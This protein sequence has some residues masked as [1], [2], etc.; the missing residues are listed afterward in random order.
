MAYEVTQ[1]DL[2]VLRQGE[3]EI[4]LK[5][6]LLNSNFKVLDSLEGNIVNDSFSQD[7][8]SI[9]RRSYSCDLK[10][11]NSTF[12]IGK[13][14]K[15]W[16]DKRIRVFYG[17]NS[18]R[19]N[20][21]IWYQLGIFC[22][23]NMKYSSTGTDKTLSLTCGDLMALYD[24]TLN[25]QLHG[26]GSSP[27]APDYAVKNL[28]IPAGEDIRLSII[29]TL[30]E[31]GITKYI[32]ED[33]GKPIPYDLTFATGTTY[34]DV[35]TKIRDLYDSWEFY[36]DADGTFIWRQTP[37]GLNEPVVLDNVI[38]QTLVKDEDA[39]SKFTDIYNVTE[40]WG[41]V[42]EL[43]KSDRYADTS[44]YS[45]NTYNIN[46]DI[47]TS[48]QDVDNLTQISFKVL[49]DNLVA[50]KF[51]IN[52]L[53]PI[54]IY[55]GDG[56]PLSEGTLKA[57]NIYVFRYRRLTPEQNALFLLGQFQCYGRYVEESQD[58]PFSVPN[59]GYEIVNS[60]DYD[61]LSDDA[62]CY[63]QAEYLT[64]KS[65]AM[66]DTISL[67]ML[68]VPWLEVNTKIE[69]TPRYNNTKNQY[70]IKNLSWSTGEGVM[71]ATLYKFMESF[72]YVYNRNKSK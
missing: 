17:L 68:V 71:N 42:L 38:M 5:V 54:P 72:S 53:S 3:Q 6:E 55:D 63:N 64:Y 11:L 62:A 45:N 8:E 47:F 34:A 9:Q 23:I 39:D 58:C 40:V 13:D 14:K 4:R 22:Y 51:S 7:S 57:N 50:P 1:T 18:V 59:L 44:T 48:W 30:K 35:W 2:S 28:I 19:E 27:N 10:V 29:A 33:I 52:N 61:N 15:I 21:V 31:A 70:I 67:T 24:G 60:V 69:Y 65:T 43:D 49:N 66:M 46:L 16:L 37:T 25:G 12:I 32:V 56:N 41:K 26:K 36:F 20:R